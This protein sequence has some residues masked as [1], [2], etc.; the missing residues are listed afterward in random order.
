MNTSFLFRF[1]DVLDKRNSRNGSITS[2]SLLS[3]TVYRKPTHT[4]R[5]LQKTSHH[6]KYQKLTVA[7]TRLSRVN[8]NTRITDKTQKPSQLRNISSTLRRKGF[9]T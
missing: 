8:S 4:N 7:K 9:P 5:Y 1:L 3:T 2:R 6:P